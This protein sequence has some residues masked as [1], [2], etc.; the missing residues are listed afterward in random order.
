MSP[1]RSSPPC[2]GETARLRVASFP[3]RAAHTPGAAR[4]R[5]RAVLPGWGMCVQDPGLVLTFW[6]TG[7]R[8]APRGWDFQKLPVLVQ[9]LW[10]GFCPRGL[11]NAGQQSAVFAQHQVW[12]LGW[13]KGF[14]RNGGKAKRIFCCPP[15]V[16]AGL[17]GVRG[18]L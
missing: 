12:V 3:T 17:C 7:S 11:A 4:D 1:A 15:G 8:E 10:K 2:A 18:N 13:E 6:P 14:R 16:W 9:R 5:D